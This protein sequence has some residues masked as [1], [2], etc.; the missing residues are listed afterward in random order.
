MA[1]NISKRVH[2]IPASFPRCA[3]TVV[4]PS[5]RLQLVVDE[6]IVP[7]VSR[8]GFT[9]LCTHGTSFNKSLWEMVIVTLLQ[10]SHVAPYIKRVL[11]VDAFNHGDSALVNK[12]KLIKDKAHWPDVSRDILQVLAHFGVEAPVIGIGH[13]FGGGALAHASIMAPSAFWAT[14]FVEPIIFL[15]ESQTQRIADTTLNRR[16]RWSSYDEAKA[17]FDRSRGMADW[18][19]QQRQTY[20]D[21]AIY[22]T[23]EGDEDF[24]TLKTT[25]EQEAAT[26]LAAPLPGL[27]ELLEASR[28]RH[29]FILGEK[30]IVLNATARARIEEISHKPG[31]VKTLPGVGHLVPMTHPHLLA[32]E[33][34][35]VL[36]QVVGSKTESKL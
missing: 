27:P 35:R 34:A 24:W 5:T 8:D 9:L 19:P 7:T 26:Y 22:Q 29:F 2:T 17:A 33:L 15:M 25:K 10:T 16:D 18:D 23:R 36:C 3:N 11:A 31:W 20:I 30:S 12:A 13:S 28:Q 32:S 21:K 14:I 6:Y 4:T 1:N